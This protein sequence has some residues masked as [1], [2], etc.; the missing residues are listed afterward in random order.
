MS[1]LRALARRYVYSSFFM[2]LVGYIF[3]IIAFLMT[4]ILDD[5]YVFFIALGFM[6]LCTAIAM[7]LNFITDRYIFDIKTVKKEDGSQF[8]QRFLQRHHHL[9]RL[10]QTVDCLSILNLLLSPVM[11]YYVSYLHGAHIVSIG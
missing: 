1:E 11:F 5:P 9:L 8:R 4:D 2:L 6:V 3:P 7:C 10:H